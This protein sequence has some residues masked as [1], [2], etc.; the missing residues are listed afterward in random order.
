MNTNAFNQL[1]TNRKS[2]FDKLS[3]E[4]DKASGKIDYKNEDDR[5]WYPA[6]DK[7]GNGY[8]VIRFLPA[9][10]GEDIPFVR[11]FEH[12]FQGPG[13]SWYI[14]K[15]LTTLGRQDPV[16]EYNTKLWNTGL[17]SDKDKARKQ[18][19]RLHYISNIYIVADPANPENEGTVRL[20]KY[21]KKIFDKLY[22]ANNPTHPDEVKLDP[23]DLWEGANLKIKIRQVE[24]YR[25]Y[26][27]SSFEAPAPLFSDDKKLEEVWKKEYPLQGF[28][29]PKDFKSYEELQAKFYRVMG[30]APIGTT[31]KEDVLNVMESKGTRILKPKEVEELASVL[32]E[33]E[34]D[35]DDLNYFAKLAEDEE[36]LI[37]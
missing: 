34:E 18:K 22:E 3:A 10:E 1:K 15:S 23:F 31:S 19:R 2:N 36:S 30:L 13:G 25:N 32:P 28:I 8:A 21:G 27:S 6:V 16:S 4:L 12:G 29:D 20:F 35:S 37:T 14:E 24:G 9:A 26:D 33:A 17:E 5:M 11:L 7:V